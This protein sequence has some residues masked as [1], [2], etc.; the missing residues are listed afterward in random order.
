MIHIKNLNFNYRK[1]QQLFTNLN[2]EVKP[3]TIVG[4]LGK[5]GAGK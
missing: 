4:M 3:G 5:N 2:L 1:N